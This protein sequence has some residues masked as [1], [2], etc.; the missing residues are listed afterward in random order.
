[1]TLETQTTSSTTETQT[2]TSISG[3]GI[4]AACGASITEC[5]D[6]TSSGSYTLANNIN[7]GGGCLNITASNV[8]LDCQGFSI[9]GDTSGSS[10]NVT[11]FLLNNF[12][13][14]QNCI[15]LDTSPVDNNLIQIGIALSAVNNN[16][17]TNVT[18]QTNGTRSIAISIENNAHT[19]RITNST[20]WANGSS[21]NNLGIQLSS[22]HNNTVEN[23]T[24]RTQGGSNGNEGIRIASGSDNNTIVNNS[25]STNGTSANYGISIASNSHNTAIEN[26]TIYSNGTSNNNI[27][28]FINGASNNTVRNNTL[29]PYGTANAYGINIQSSGDNNTIE[30]NAISTHGTGSNNIGIAFTTSRNNT[31]AHNIIQT[32]GSTGGNRGIQLQIT[33]QTHLNNNTI[34]TAGGSTNYG[35]EFTQTVENSTVSNNHINATATTGGQGIHVNFRSTNN[36]FSGNTVYSGTGGSS[37]ALYVELS[38]N[39]TFTDNTFTQGGSN[40]PVQIASGNNT[41]TNTNLNASADVLWLFFGASNSQNNFTNTSF[42]KPFGA[43]TI[44]PRVE[45]NGTNI[46]ATQLNISDNKAFLNGTA[47]SFFNTSANITLTGLSFSNPQ[48]LFD[49]E[50]DGTYIACDSGRCTETGYAGGTFTMNVSGFTSYSTSEAEIGCGSILT[51][52]TTLSANLSTTDTCFNITTSNI[53]IDCAGYNISGNGATDR[54]AFNLTGVTNVTIRNCNIEDFYYGVWVTNG[55]NYTIAENNNLTTN[56]IAGIRFDSTTFYGTVRQNII[57]GGSR[58][59]WNTNCCSGPNH[60]VH[61]N[62]I[63]NAQ[64]GIMDFASSNITNNHIFGGNSWQIYLQGVSGN[65]VENNILRDSPEGFIVNSGASNNIFINNTVI[66]HSTHGIRLSGSSNNIFRNNTFANNTVHIDVAAGGFSAFLSNYQ[67]DV[68]TSNTADG[69]PVYYIYAN[70]T[71]VLENIETKHLTFANEQFVVINNVSVIEGDPITLAFSHNITITNVTQTYGKNN[72][73]LYSI[74]DSNFTNIS[75]QH[76]N[77]PSQMMFV[78]SSYQNNFTNL[79]FHNASSIMLQLGT[80][81]GTAVHTNTFN[82]TTFEGPLANSFTWISTSTVG[83]LN[84]TFWNTSFINTSA[85]GATLNFPYNFSVPASVTLDLPKLIPSFNRTRLNANSL[86]FLNTTAQITFPGLSFTNPRPLFDSNDDNVFETCN[87]PQCEEINYAGGA[88]TFNVTHFSSYAASETTINCG[89]TITTH[90]NLTQNLTGTGTCLTIGADNVVL[91][92]NGHTINYSS[93]TAGYGI[94]STGRINT[95]ILNCILL[96]TDTTQF[97]AHAIYLSETN[98][99]QIYNITVRTGN[100]SDAVH[101]TGSGNNTVHNFSV[102][103]NG[104]A[105]N[106]GTGIRVNTGGDNLIAN[107]TSRTV[108]GNPAVFLSGSR[109]NLVR[110]VSVS[111][112]NQ[113]L[114]SPSGT[115]DTFINCTASGG[116]GMTLST[117]SRADNIVFVN[118]GTVQ[119]FGNH[120][121]IENSVFN[122]TQLTVSSGT[123]HTLTNVSTFGTSQGLN[124]GASNG[125]ISN[126]TF[127]GTSNNVINGNNNTFTNTTFLGTAISASAIILNIGANNTF[128]DSAVGTNGTWIQTQSASATG[129]NFTRVSFTNTTGNILISNFTMP[130]PATIGRVN[131]SITQNRAFLFS[132]NLSFLNTSA[133]IT[134][135]GITQNQAQQ[136]V[137]F[138]DDGSYVP[139]VEPDCTFISY[140][141]ST[142]VFNVSHFTSF[143]STQG[144]VNA[145][146]EKTDNPDPVNLSQ[147]TLLNYTITFNVTDGAA[148]NITIN[149]TYPADVDFITSNPLPDTGNFSWNAGNLSVN[150]SYQINITLN[151]SSLLPNGYVI[152][153]TVNATYWNSSGDELFV[154]VTESTNITLDEVSA[155]GTITTDTNLTNN[156]TSDDTCITIGADNVALDCQGYTINYSAT[157]NGNGVLASGRSNVTV[158]NC[159]ILKT[160]V[161]TSASSAIL[162]TNTDDSLVVNVTVNATGSTSAGV[163]LAGGSARNS[164]Y[165]S[166][167]N[168]SAYPAVFLFLVQNATLQNVTGISTISIGINSFGGGNHT[169]TNVTARGGTNAGIQLDGDASDIRINGFSATT[170]S[171]SGISQGS[172]RNILIENGTANAPTGIIVSLSGQNITLGNVSAQGTNQIAVSSSN[173]RQITIR[174]V[175]ASSSATS[176]IRLDSVNDSV[177]EDSIGFGTFALRVSGHRNRITRSQGYD[178]AGGAGIGVTDGDNNTIEHSLGAI[179]SGSGPGILLQRAFNTTITNSSGYSPTAGG[180]SLQFNTNYTRVTHSIG[181]SAANG[182]EISSGNSNFLFNSTGRANTSGTGISVQDGN[183]TLANVS[184]T[185]SSG[186]GISIGS[187]GNTLENSSAASSTGNGLSLF[188]GS[189]N[190]TNNTLTS[191]SSTAVLISSGS[192]ILTNNTANTTGTA[193]SVGSTLNYLRGNTALNGNGFSV[194]NN[195]TLTENTA[196]GGTGYGISTG[197][198]GNL[199]ENNTFTKTTAPQACIFSSSTQNIVRNNTCSTSSISPALGMTG[200]SR[201]TFIDN[202]I[203]NA[204]T[205]GGIQL[206]DTQHNTLINNTAS[207]TGGGIGIQILGSGVYT[208]FNHTVINNTGISGIQYGIELDYNTNSY[209]F[210]NRATRAMR[211]DHSHNNTVVNT[212]INSTGLS[213]FSLV[214]SENNTIV[215]STISTA[216]LAAIA[217]TSTTL[218]NSFENTYLESNGTWITTD[219]TST[220]NNITATNFS[221]RANGTIFITGNATLPASASITQAS[222][223]IAQGRAFLNA[224]ALSFLNTSAQITLNSITF[225]QAQPIVSYDDSRAYVACVPPD[226]TPISY[227]GSTL[228][229]NVSHFTTFTSTIGGVNV[230]FEKTDNPDPLDLT[231]TTLLNYTITFNVTDG[232]A[233]NATI[234]ET[235]PANTSFVTSNP[236][237]DAGNFSWIVGNVSINTSY[238]INITLNVSPALAN[239]T[240]LSNVVNVTFQNSSGDALFVNVTENTTVANELCPIE[241]ISSTTLTENISCPGTAVSIL[242]DNTVLDCAGF[243]IN[244]SATDIGA[245]INATQRNNITIANCTVLQTNA[246]ISSAHA[247]LLD[248][249]TN[250]TVTD[251]F[252]NSTTGVGIYLDGNNTNI[253]D[254]T[255]TSDQNYSIFLANSRGNRLQNNTATSTSAHAI[256]L[257]SS[258]NNNDLINNTG[259]T[260]TTEDGIILFNSD[261]NRLT[262]NTGISNQGRGIDLVSASLNNLTQNTGFSTDDRGISVSSSPNTILIS[263][264]AT[265]TNFRGLVVEFGDNNV[266]RYN[267]ATSTSG[268]GFYLDTSNNNEITNNTINSS[269]GIGAQT[270]GANNNNF[271]NNT[272]TG[273][274]AAAIFNGDNNRID[275][276]LAIGINNGLVLSGGTGNNLTNNYAT[277]TGAGGAL[278]LASLPTYN[279]FENNTWYSSSGI[280]AHIIESAYNEFRND[281]ISSNTGTALNLLSASNN[282]TFTD[283]A[284]FSNNTWIQS[285]ADSFENNLTRTL[286]NNTATGGI[287]ISSATIP[288]SVRAGTNN[289]SIQQNRAF[290]NSTAL[291]FLNTSAQITLA[292]LSTGTVQPLVDFDDDGTFAPCTAPQCTFISYAG[293]T[294]VFNVSS[295]TSY[296]STDGGVT[297]TLTKTDTPDPLDLTTTTELNYTITV[298]V[299]SGVAH[300][301]T[302]NETYP[303][304]VSFASATPA[305]D[306]GN[307]SWNAG[308]ISNGSTY[309]INITL[310]VGTTIPNGSILTNTVNA[311][312]QNST[313]NSLFTNVTENTTVENVLCP[314]PVTTSTTLSANIT[315]PATAV[316]ILADNVVLDCAGYSINYSNETRGTGINAT[317]RNNITVRNCNIGERAALTLSPGI[318]WTTVTNS[319]IDSVNISATGTTSPGIRI[320]GG[321][322][323][324]FTNINSSSLDSDGLD[325]LSSNSNRVTNSRLIG[326][327]SRVGLFVQGTLNFIENV[328]ATGNIGIRIF[329]GSNNILNRNPSQIALDGGTA[330]NTIANSTPLVPTGGAAIQL[331]SA[332]NNII[333]NITVNTSTP[334]TA[335]QIQSASTGNNLTQITSL[336]T[337][338]SADALQIAGSNNILRNATLFGGSTGLLVQSGNTN[339]VDRVQISTNT[340]NALRLI[341]GTGNNSL[342]NITLLSDATWLLTDSVANNSLENITFLNSNGSIGLPGNSTLPATITVDTSKINIT[343]NRAFLNST[344]LSFLNTSAQITLSGLALTTPEPIVDFNDDGLYQYCSPPQCTFVSFG[345]GTLVYNVSSFTGY[346]SAGNVTLTKTDNP[347]PVTSGSTL[348]YQITINN[349]GADAIFNATLVET[350]PAGVSFVSSSPAPTSGNNTF[351]IATI[352][353]STASTINITLSVGSTLANGTLLNNSANLTF[354]NGLGQNI[355]LDA[356]ETTTVV[357]VP[358]LVTAKTDT[359]DPVAKGTT[360]NYTI[361]VTNIGGEFAYNTTVTEIYPSDTLFLS[362]TPAPTLGNNTFA[363][364]TLALGASTTVNITLNVSTSVANG[365]VLNNTYNV[366]FANNS[367]QNL[368]ITNS[369][370][371]T[372]L[373]SPVI[374]TIK[375]DT[376]DPVIKG[377]ALNYTILINNTGDDTAFNLTI[378]ENYPSG[379]SFATATPAPTLGNNTWNLGTIAN[380]T[381]TTINITVIVGPTVPNGTL[382]NNTATATFA[383]STGQSA[384]VNDS[385]LTTVLGIPLITATKT[386]TPDPAT[387]GTQLNYTITIT[388]TGDEIAYNVTVVDGHD[389]NVAFHNSS[390]AP[391]SGNNTFSLGNLTP[392]ASTTV[393]ITVNISSTFNGTLNNT[394]N[395][396]FQNLSGQVDTQT[397]NANTTVNI[398][399]PTPAAPAVT[400]GGGGGGAGASAVSTTTSFTQNQ[401]TQNFRRNDRITFLLEEELHT[402]TLLEVTT[403]SVTI[404]VASTPEVYTL[405]RG[406]TRAID[407]TDDGIP[408]ISVRV[409]DI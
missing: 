48:P 113:G 207:T 9:T 298:N 296:T 241:I 32:N 278:Q 31:V 234:N 220:G 363:L 208:S 261:S 364:G 276:S 117:R 337:L 294:F 213:P 355:T 73:Q 67:N 267:N 70:S 309:Q 240:V 151:V 322:S 143:S 350:Y 280:A 201:N 23:T 235:Y 316:N 68:D 356:N 138:E 405:L 202:I 362:S 343:L 63:S 191:A 317:N 248:Q 148:F 223:R 246:S 189:N 93:Q 123:N 94:N 334:G 397:A 304:N 85:N 329:G 110:N 127:R 377:T 103:S 89:D 185:S 88:F 141:G 320:S 122:N 283:V 29:R 331:V 10:G 205:G 51:S 196:L 231:T 221:G 402:I 100:S 184:G 379:V 33:A 168:S 28:I 333:T 1:G 315:C 323:N 26:N 200:G 174:N 346:S 376:P 56:T 342:Q 193:Y 125:Q 77:Q 297:L 318:N 352:A 312:Y 214:S 230:T 182:I 302:I 104:G 183:N 391:T 106:S 154:N 159:I 250:S 251:N 292:G 324:F 144:G 136:I 287:L 60:I 290:I 388:N 327:S 380:G 389:A 367:G 268:F 260:S 90:T 87:P 47:L 54:T 233:F 198:T 98:Q 226:C 262:N 229:F 204:N 131:L 75:L 172:G 8:Q 179:T 167:F 42:T 130:T 219:G 348:T 368:T 310:S 270:S 59:V 146:L 406:Q 150:S 215:N 330:Q 80:G 265:G 381:E 285:D 291:P 175:S 16:N 373:G 129:N 72:L 224:S 335:I 236:L 399:A 383:N 142:L 359:P 36:T 243:T 71:A 180:I 252:V 325:L 74:V 24:I 121:T 277:H 40:A 366:T 37:P 371:T 386:D 188:A 55:S 116:S 313:G 407:A 360:L 282:N 273:S 345:G 30:H 173:S 134:L 83:G 112:G 126:S 206:R 115:N 114:Y 349:T 256:A 161:S 385:E 365:S 92:C 86:P 35:I 132:T 38:N 81:L 228:V 101:I 119:I 155:C 187:S 392:G 181:E 58:G 319:T 79:T 4:S 69:L 195:H 341:S 340:G 281:N 14:V 25:I 266:I 133:Q 305:P 396:T 17:I 258:S 165:N 178:S 212:T 321:S 34:N 2:S 194:G 272:F 328:T 401:L 311:T 225:N 217:L 61:N 45:I 288:A 158:R 99:S 145:T 50:D 21:F 299:T 170:G 13:H 245:G 354:G 344:N 64:F 237:P 111:T 39:N 197:G 20:L 275:K 271:T 269:T 216:I 139:C 41:F 398:L 257:F 263:N 156:I 44:V 210:G 403:Q 289:L 306:F 15:V 128:I 326:G 91:D 190:I 107:G 358:E 274:G 390:P 286:F 209:L 222:L 162:Y 5:C 153:N 408:D 307:F 157:A 43:I 227:D 247:I 393:N 192:N 211:L 105:S 6:I 332:A 18:V 53:V 284:L 12:I 361:T 52:D 137:D 295:F 124:Y 166:S 370:L 147:D 108:T 369:T 96:Q 232:A 357:G 27:A 19:N 76:N 336:M 169:L 387:N 160:N 118:A 375:S 66:N 378:T 249:A 308:N 404:E 62:T 338:G 218:N 140:D 3:I 199:I 152:N 347:D 300:N 259:Q 303:A 95:S 394:A 351:V 374:I 78:Q 102:S 22:A 97:L 400:G 409:I 279:L 301:L 82:Q 395:V 11:L 254:N 171:G 353:G 120:N 46:S 84:N 384:S 65:R 239:G 314:Y 339:I 49:P 253:T 293:G 135:N 244:Y 57:R 255:A 372:V 109:N 177:I 242:A 238:Q 176:A 164:I 382:L 264:N 203:I 186:A 163:E 149:E 7:A